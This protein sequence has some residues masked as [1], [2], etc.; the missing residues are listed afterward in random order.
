MGKKERVGGVNKQIV[1]VKL[2][3]PLAIMPEYKTSGA[4]GFDLHACQAITIHPGEHEIIRLGIAFEV[5]DGYEIQ[6]RPRS[7]MSFNTSLIAKNTIGTIDSDYRGEVSYCLL[8]VGD[9]PCFIDAGERVCQAVLCQV[10]K[11]FLMLVD[12][13]SDTERGSGGFGSTGKK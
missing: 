7:G 10:P 11:A 8:N 12:E 5:P 2:L 3:H 6:I 1:K 13:L 9:L 4:S